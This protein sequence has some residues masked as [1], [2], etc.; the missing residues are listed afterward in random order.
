MD[1]DRLAAAAIRLRSHLEAPSLG[2]EV[3]S[4][5][6]AVHAAHVALDDTGAPADD[7]RGRPLSLASRIR[8]LARHTAPLETAC[9]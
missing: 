2:G 6:G 3:A 1:R 5:V 8:L 9:V 4:L 7:G